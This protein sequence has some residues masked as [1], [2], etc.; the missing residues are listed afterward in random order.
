MVKA[1]LLSL[2][3]LATGATA[4]LLPLSEEYSE[5]WNALYNALGSSGQQVLGSDSLLPADLKEY[6]RLL[7]QEATKLQHDVKEKA[8][9]AAKQA[10]DLAEKWIADGKQ[11]IKQH[12]QTCTSGV[13]L[14]LFVHFPFLFVLLPRYQ[15]IHSLPILT[16]LNSVC[17]R[18]HKS[19][20]YTDPA[21]IFY[22]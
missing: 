5:T 20:I 1:S 17:N 4:S 16:S 11:F 9:S 15:V 21:S 19:N 13:T 6:E 8:K 22:R 14:T 10:G 2:G 18:I 12:G 7:R 3:L